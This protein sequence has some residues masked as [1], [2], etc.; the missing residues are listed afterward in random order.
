MRPLPR[1]R[2]LARLR[3]L[4]VIGVALPAAAASQRPPSLTEW[5]SDLRATTPIAPAWGLEAHL[6]E[7][8]SIQRRSLDEMKT[9]LAAERA[10]GAWKFSGGYEHVV[11]RS[12][13]ARSTEERFL[14]EANASHRFASWLSGSEHEKTEVRDMRQGWATRWV[15]RL[16]ANVGGHAI[17]FVT[18][19]MA[20]EWSYDARYRA[21]NKSMWWYGLRV[22]TPLPVDADLFYYDEYDTERALP[23][24][25]AVGLNLHLRR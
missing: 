25:T 8:G 9:G 24:L 21:V 20:R 2:A 23:R 6:T 17:P 15:D 19:W 18:P 1:L 16:R 10:F 7:Y 5:R 12:A 3:H 11:L 22:R 4:L 13:V 14:F